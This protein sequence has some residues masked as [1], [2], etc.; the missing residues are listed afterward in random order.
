MTKNKAIK[1]QIRLRMEETGE[2]YTTAKRY[3]ENLPNI[4]T[5]ELGEEGDSWY[6]EGTIDPAEALENVKSWLEGTVP[7]ILEDGWE[8]F[9]ARLDVHPSDTWFFVPLSSKYP[10]DEQVLRNKDSHPEL[11][12]GQLLMKGVLVQDNGD[13]TSWY[14]SFEEL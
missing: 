6:V 10:E 7:E 9:S 12:T 14:T 4:T 8:K 5:Y 3:I 2:N 11:Y 13:T 1:E